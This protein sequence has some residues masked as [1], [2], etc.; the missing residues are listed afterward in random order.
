M[1][2]NI[3][4]NRR[5]KKSNRYRENEKPLITSVANFKTLEAELFPVEDIQIGELNPVLGRRVH[6]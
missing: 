5:L 1:Q 3:T 4:E 6:Y 2:T